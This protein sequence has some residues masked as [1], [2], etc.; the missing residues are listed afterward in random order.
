MHSGAYPIPVTPSNGVFLSNLS[1]VFTDHSK[2][3]HLTLE[4]LMAK[5]VLGSDIH[6]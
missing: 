3:H 1:L 5:A 4:D 6:V 2:G